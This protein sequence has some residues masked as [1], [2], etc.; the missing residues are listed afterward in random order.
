[1]EIQKHSRHNYVSGQKLDLEQT[2]KSFFLEILLVM[3]IANIIITFVVSLH[4][5]YR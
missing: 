4:K 1:M 2:W 5:L 3:Y